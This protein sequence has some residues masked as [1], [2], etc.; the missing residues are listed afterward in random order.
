M[1]EFQLQWLG[2][3]EGERLVGEMEDGEE[4]AHREDLPF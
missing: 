1:L 3:G 2:A 4:E